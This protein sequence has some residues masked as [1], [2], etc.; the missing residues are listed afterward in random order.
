VLVNA[1]ALNAAVPAAKPPRN[2]RRDREH[3]GHI[4]VLLLMRVGSY[5]FGCFLSLVYCTPG[6]LPIIAEKVDLASVNPVEPVRHLEH[7]EHE[8]AVG[9]RP[10]FVTAAS[11]PPD[12][13]A[14]AAYPLSA[15]QTPL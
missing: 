7:A 12:K 3:S 5:K 14:S 9:P 4:P 15:D 10:C 6:L 2:R 13:V 11:G 8:P 1:P